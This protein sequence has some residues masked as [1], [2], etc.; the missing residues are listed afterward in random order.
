MDDGRRARGE[1]GGFAQAKRVQGL[2][3]EVGSR[4]SRAR[5]CRSANRLVGRRSVLDE[6][7]LEE[8]DH[9]MEKLRRKWKSE[10]EGAG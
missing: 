7:I 4:G 8:L 5:K 9:V 2:E 10:K 1:V 6:E 3:V